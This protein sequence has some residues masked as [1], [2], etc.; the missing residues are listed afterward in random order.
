MATHSPAAAARPSRQA[1]A[2]DG[3]IGGAL[4]AEV[5]RL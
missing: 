5:S 4:T 3:T 1:G 2:T